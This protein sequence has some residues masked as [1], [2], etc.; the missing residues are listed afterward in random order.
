MWARSCALLPPLRGSMPALHVQTFR[1]VKP[2]EKSFQALSAATRK[3]GQ[4]QSCLTEIRQGAR[5]AVLTTG[6]SLQ[7]Q[8]NFVIFKA[9]NNL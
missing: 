9:V 3:G 6:G 7:L 8:C 2:L 4:T 1:Q 5:C